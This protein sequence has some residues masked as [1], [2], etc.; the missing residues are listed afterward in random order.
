M[1]T[2]HVTELDDRHALPLSGQRPGH[3]LAGGSAAQDD[4]VVFL[5]L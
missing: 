4:N 3:E 2:K 5:E 1:L